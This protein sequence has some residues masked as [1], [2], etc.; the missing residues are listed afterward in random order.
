[1]AEQEPQVGETWYWNYVYER[2]RE[3]E[4]TA[5]G[6]DIYVVAH[7]D[8]FYH[9]NTVKRKELIAKVPP[10]PPW[11]DYETCEVATISV[12][13]VIAYWIGRILGKKTK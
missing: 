10:S 11:I 1:M 12:A 8:P 6:D 5:V 4:V 2:T 9:C 7:Y 13:L 3:V